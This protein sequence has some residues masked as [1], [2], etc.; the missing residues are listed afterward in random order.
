M[1]QHTRQSGNP[2]RPSAARAESKCEP[3]DNPADLPNDPGGDCEPFPEDTPPKLPDP[4]KCPDPPSECHCP[5]PPPTG[6]NCLDELIE[7][8]NREISEAERAKVFKAELETLLKQANAVKLDYTQEKYDKLVK[9]WVRLDG[10]IKEL[11]RKLVC[12]VPCWRCLIECFICPL[13]NDIRDREYRLYGDGTLYTTVNSLQDMRYW[14]ERNL[15]AKKRVLDRIKAVLKAWET[16]AQTIE[17]VLADNAKLIADA[18][19]LLAPDAAKVVYDVF[20]KLVPLHLAIAP[21]ASAGVGTAIDKQYTEFC[22][23]D[24]GVPDDCCG[25]DVGVLTVRQRLIGPQ[26]YLVKPSDYFPIICCIA[27]QRYLPANAA[28]AAAKSEFEIVDAQV[29][30]LTG[31]MDEKLKALEKTAK[32][33]LPADCD[34]NEPE[35]QT[36][37]PGAMS[38]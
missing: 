25:P 27:K 23:C 26:P 38:R 22:E 3:S 35:E 20:L 31:E 29:K 14:R 34:W 37:T 36:E 1:S 18:G 15:D 8:Q 13:I 2:S 10:E 28:Y 11:I 12:A 17:K 24:E 9:E 19:K 30:R 16:P 21:P 7:I 4:P 6:T 32:A 5:T 33:A